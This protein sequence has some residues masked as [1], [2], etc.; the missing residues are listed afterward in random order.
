MPYPVT[1]QTLV[2]FGNSPTFPTGTNVFTLNDATKGRLDYNYLGSGSS[3]IVDISSSVTLI[4]I[5][6]GYQLQQDQFQVNKGTVRVYDPNGWWNPQ[7]T[8]SPYYGYLTP[9]KKINIQTIYGGVTRPFFAGY[10]NAYNYSFPTTMSFGYVDLD[11]ADAFRLFNMATISTVTGGTSGQTTGQRINTILDNLQFPAGLRNIDTG[12]NLVQADPATQRTALNA[13]KN[14]E[15]AEQGA[16]YMESNGYATF[17]SRT[18]VTKTNGAAPITYFANDGSGIS[19]AGITFAHDDKLIVNQCTVT[20]VSGTA[21]SYS[22]TASIP[23]YFPHTVQQ[24]NVVGYSDSDASNVAKISV[25]TRKNT[26]IR[27]DQ[28]SLD[29]TTPNYDAG[30]LAALTLDYFSTVDIKNVQSNGSTIEKVL[31]V[32]GSNYRITPNTFDISFTTSAPIVSGFI[33][34]STLYGVLD[35]TPLGW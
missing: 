29:L 28:I 20:N 32:M 35:Q 16:F 7:N 34:S 14:V 5:S 13:M 4:D 3:F 17:K 15:F 25:Q 26:T 9:N 21:Q 27:I 19:Y 23:T 8:S 24:N 10:I 6:G 12:D 22:D 11:V 1:V 30:I 2:D 33:L 18:N 31:Q